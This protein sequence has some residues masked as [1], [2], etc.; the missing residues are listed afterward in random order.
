MVRIKGLIV[1]SITWLTTFP[2]LRRIAAIRTEVVDFPE[3]PVTPINTP[4]ARE[5][6]RV[7]LRIRNGRRVSVRKLRINS[8]MDMVVMPEALSLPR[9]AELHDTRTCF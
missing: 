4:R 1:L 7:A 2:R 9:R 5:R 6:E 8:R 3:L